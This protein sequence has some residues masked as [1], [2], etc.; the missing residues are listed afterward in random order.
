MGGKKRSPR[1]A[2]KKEASAPG[3]HIAASGLS[4]EINAR[5]VMPLDF[6]PSQLQAAARAVGL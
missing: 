2:K 1:A 3:L 5:V 6:G 4:N